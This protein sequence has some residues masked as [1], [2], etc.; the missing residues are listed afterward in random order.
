MATTDISTKCFITQKWRQI[1]NR[2]IARDMGCDLGV[3]GY[4]IYGNAYIHHMNP[5]LLTD[6]QNSTD[7]LLNPEYLITTTFKTHN[8]I[9]YGN[10]DG[11][12]KMPVIRT[13]NDTTPWKR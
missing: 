7:I 8:A 2:V 9:H 4:E 11:L 6:I 13:P 3:E 5:I 12:Y 10:V 1:R